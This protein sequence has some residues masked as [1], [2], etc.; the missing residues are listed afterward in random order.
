VT[1]T[2]RL[3]AGLAVVL[4]T[5]AL[6]SDLAARPGTGTADLAP[7]AAAVGSANTRVE[8]LEL[9]RWI[10]D[11]RPGLTVWD[12][13][14]EAAWQ[15][16]HVPG[17]IRVSPEDLLDT[18]RP[19]SFGTLVIYGPDGAA[20]AEASLLLRLAGVRDVRALDRGVLGWL[21]EVMMP[22]VPDSIPP[23]NAEAWAA[24]AELAEYFGGHT[25]AESS[26][27][28]ERWRLGAGERSPDA[29]VASV[30]RDARRRGCGF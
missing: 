25:H 11:R 6:L 14:I 5:G 9:A 30:V 19:P 13:R 26:V 4:G 16:F 29:A 28:P 10:R 8:P 3:L 17:A 24:V 22:I 15:D 2:H 1:R 12:V 18:A 7:Y 23:E 21:D 20:S 27:P